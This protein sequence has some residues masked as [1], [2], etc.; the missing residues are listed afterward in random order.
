MGQ[1]GIEPSRA[2]EF[3][4]LFEA[5][6]MKRAMLGKLAYLRSKRGRRLQFIAGSLALLSA[7]SMTAI[8]ADVANSLTVK[9]VTALLS[10][11]SG[12]ITLSIS[13][14]YDDRETRRISDGAAKFLALRDETDLL[15]K[16]TDMTDKQQLTAI[17]SLHTRYAAHSG[18][19]DHYI[20]VVSHDSRSRSMRSRSWFRDRRGDI[21]DPI[22]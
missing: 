8:I 5:A 11:A 18:D 9:I 19:F 6:Q 12:L 10:L 15:R 20:D 13:T 22:L 16:R 21:V 4:R 7:A 2:F 14:F 17:E 1:S 3:E